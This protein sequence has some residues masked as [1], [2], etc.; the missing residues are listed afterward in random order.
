[1]SSEALH[2][3]VRARAQA[4]VVD[5]LA[6]IDERVRGHISALIDAQ[7]GPWI[8]GKHAD[9]ADVLH[10]YREAALAGGK[11]LR[12]G[13]AHWAFEGAGGDPD[14]PAVLDVAVAIE[15]L[16]TFALIH[17]DVMDGSTTRRGLDTIHVQY[18]RRHAALELRGDPA[19][20]GESVAVLVGDLAF[21][22]AALLMTRA[23]TDCARTFFELCA[24]LMVGQFLDIE[25]AAHGPLP[26]TT[27]AAQIT[28]LKTARYTVVGPLVIGAA[29]AGR[30]EE[31]A[32]HL[33]AYG[34]PVGHAFQ[35]RDDLLGAFGDPE[36]TGK[37]VGDDLA[38]G[39]VTRL[40]ELGLERCQGADRE[41]LLRL[42]SDRMEEHD[43]ARA[44]A[45]LEDCGA[46]AEVEAT[47]DQLVRRGTEAIERS[48]LLPEIREVLAGAAH[49][50]ANRDR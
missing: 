4:R 48:P 46:R 19:H 43:V 39:K 10:A 34:H 24:D 41:L 29:L 40:L 35:L 21:A 2:G 1:M 13:F 18:R 3:V 16:H 6:R 45:L 23:P 49:L 25:S 42:G 20:Y 36:R 17:D 7:M 8:D 15:L 32:P 44:A 11:R 27:R 28:E 9:V 37:A 5:D 12:P 33:E 31:L 47:I 14:D 30:G 26:G 22:H 38:Q 50:I